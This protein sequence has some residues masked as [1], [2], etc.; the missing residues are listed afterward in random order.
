[1][2]NI[3]YSAFLTEYTVIYSRILV[4]SIQIDVTSGSVYINEAK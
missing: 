3:F 2:Q 4:L 1:M